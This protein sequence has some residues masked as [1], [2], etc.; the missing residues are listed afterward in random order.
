VIA[1]RGSTA[2]EGVEVRLEEV[3][4]LSRSNTQVVEPHQGDQIT[5]RCG[6]AAGDQIDDL[7]RKMDGIILEMVE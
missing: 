7:G 4:E 3:E 6:P 2:L 1:G 5:L